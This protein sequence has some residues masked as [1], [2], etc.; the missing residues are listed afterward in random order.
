MFPTVSTP[1]SP[2]RVMKM[3]MRGWGGCV[4]GCQDDICPCSVL[5]GKPH[6]YN[7]FQAQ[8]LGLV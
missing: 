8:V 6:V 5:A 4:D 7:S 3:D 2:G 1:E